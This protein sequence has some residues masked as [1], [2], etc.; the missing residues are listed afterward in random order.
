[1]GDLVG[2]IAGVIG[3]EH[4]HDKLALMTSR[5]KDMATR[6]TEQQIVIGGNTT[7]PNKGR[8]ARWL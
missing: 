6:W 3:T 4:K 2:K 5:N 7:F 8:V 1:M